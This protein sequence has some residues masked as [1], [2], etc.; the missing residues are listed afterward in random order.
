MLC[1][2]RYHKSRQLDLNDFDS[3]NDNY[4]RDGVRACFLTF[5]PRISGDLAV[6]FLPNIGP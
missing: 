3:H 5:V 2:V 6:F 1:V 4:T